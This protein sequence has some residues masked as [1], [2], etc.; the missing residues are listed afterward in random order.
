[1][2]IDLPR[3]PFDL[4]VADPRSNFDLVLSGS[5]NAGILTCIMHLKK[6]NIIRRITKDERQIRNT[7]TQ[8]S[9]MIH[10]FV[11]KLFAENDRL[12]D[13]DNLIG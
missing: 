3:L 13:I 2:H 7:K 8:N 9:N 4:N 10:I 11:T 5:I 6:T 12:F 1:M